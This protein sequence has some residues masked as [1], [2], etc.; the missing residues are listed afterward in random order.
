ME[1]LRK[2]VDLNII[3]NQETDFQTNAGWQE[4]LVAFEDEILS[5]ILNP[6]ENYETIRYIHKPY[7]G[8]TTNVDDKQTDIWFYFYFATSGNTPNYVQDYSAQ[9]ITILE[10]EKMMKQSS[11]SF[12]RLEFF[13]TPGIL[14][15]SGNTIGYQPPTRQNRKLVFAKNLSLPLGE[16]YYYTPL[17]GYVHLPVFKGSNYENKENMYF[18]WFQDESVLKETNLSGSTTGNTFF[19]TA[20]FFNAKDGSIQ[21]FTNDC[22]GTG[23]TI[24]E[25]NDMYYQV[26][27]D[28]TDYSYKVY[29]FNGV[30]K[31]DQVGFIKKPINFFEKG[32]G[33]CPNGLTYYTCSNVTPTPT[34]TLTPV[35]PT[36]TPTLTATP[37]ATPVFS[38]CSDCGLSLNG[39]PSGLLSVMTAGVITSSIGCTVGEYA[40]DWYLDDKIGD[41]EFTS[42]STI[43]AD[44]NATVA[45]PF[46]NEPVQGGTWYPV[47]K[48]IYLN[49]TKYSAYNVNGSSYSPDLLNCL[50]TVTVSNYNCTTGYQN[51]T[52]PININYTNTTTNSALANRSIRFDL[53]SDTNYF[54]WNFIGYLVSDF[55]K[56]SY[57]NVPTQTKTQLEYWKI[58]QDAGSTN[59][60][61]NPKI[62]N[63]YNLQRVADLTSFTFSE[64]NYLIIELTPNSGN[65]NTNWNFQCKCLTDSGC[66]DIIDPTADFGYT[67]AGI[68]MYYDNEIC[69]YRIN[70]LVK[71]NV[72]S[73]TSYYDNNFTK[74]NSLNISPYIHS[75]S[76]P[77]T[78][79]I[80]SGRTLANDNGDGYVYY[81]CQDQISYTTVTK[82]GNVITFD[83]DNL[84]DYNAYKT[85]YTN[86]M[87]RSYMLNYT[88]DTTNIN[89]YKF[90]QIGVIEGINCGDNAQGQ[91]YYTSHVSSPIDFNDSIKRITYTIVNVT[92]GL[93]S[94]ITCDTRYS[95]VQYYISLVNS[96]INTSNFSYQTYIRKGDGG[97]YYKAIA[98]RSFSD[99]VYNQTASN[100]GIY[101]DYIYVKPSVCESTL[102]SK[103][104]VDRGV[105]YYNYIHG[106]SV[107]ITNESDPLNNFKVESLVNY[108]SKTYTGVFTKIF[109]KINGVVKTYSVGT[110]ITTIP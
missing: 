75:N 15:V 28:K 78:P 19:M 48:S 47:I 30:V 5:T 83:F 56:I 106:I 50:S 64:G 87:S 96:A 104:W 72:L 108:T 12:F 95:T 35:S 107:T 13:K 68:T 62:Y 100:T 9:G 22:H 77:P 42:A 17:N 53:S 63:G 82:V 102:I 7:S 16:K 57:F 49:G 25:Q 6:I 89:H 10:N 69:G 94:G 90:F 59:L 103:N 61:S 45:H 88:S 32:G 26:D 66:A 14:D 55:I 29:Y 1:I 27:I 54:A 70:G 101:T 41:P 76:T 20:K 73:G 98:V 11:E 39:V 74:Y 4:N 43:G 21:D 24:N 31:C 109:E 2:N 46:A 51:S 71:T 97:N 110:T 99:Y 33:S 93:P 85:Q 18:F 105:S 81:Y 65:S 44:P 92:N 40:I 67:T 60:T 3:L 36:P 58:G 23:Y 37:T 84:T 80:F 52:Y 8:M 79:I 86:L 38:K 91:S 34:P